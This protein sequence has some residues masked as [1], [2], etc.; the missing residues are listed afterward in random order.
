ML[1]PCRGVV[2][3]A[4]GA[5]EFFGRPD[6]VGHCTESVFGT[7]T[8]RV[9]TSLCIGVNRPTEI[10]LMGVRQTRLWSGALQEFPGLCSARQ[11]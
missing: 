8:P 7:S 10:R 6:A 1:L 2:H 9:D 5:G 11:S 4:T 3:A